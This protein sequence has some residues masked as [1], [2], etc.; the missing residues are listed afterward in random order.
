MSTRS[1]AIAVMLMGLVAV[2]CGG[3]TRGLTGRDLYV[4]SCA[5]CHGDMGEGAIGP[6]VGTGS[7][8]VSLTDGQIAGVITVGP[9]TMPAFPRLSDEQVDSLVAYLRQLDTP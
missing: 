6:A 1:L 9:G 3:S 8:T 5:S 7:N 4:E 2:S